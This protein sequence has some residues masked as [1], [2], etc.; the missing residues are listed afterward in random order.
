MNDTSPEIE[1]LVHERMMALT[2]EERFLMGARMFVTA[3]EL[4]LAS[5]P[6]GLSEGEIR[7][8]LFERFYGSEIDDPELLKALE[9][10]HR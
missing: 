1:R 2:G 9:R 3:R 7:V 6:P 5:F 8:R 4:V 10:G